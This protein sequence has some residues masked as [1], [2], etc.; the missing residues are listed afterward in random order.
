MFTAAILLLFITKTH[1]SIPRYKSVTNIQQDTKGL[2]AFS[3]P[4][5]KYYKFW[6]LRVYSK[7]EDM[8]NIYECDIKIYVICSFVYFT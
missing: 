3:E 7:M 4:T 8:R 2:V 5:R 6:L 1:F